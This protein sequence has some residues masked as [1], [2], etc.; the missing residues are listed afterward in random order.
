MLVCNHYLLQELDGIANHGWVVDNV[1]AGFELLHCSFLQQFIIHMKTLRMSILLEHVG[2]PQTTYHGYYI[3]V[4]LFVCLATDLE[5]QDFLR[6]KKIK[7][8]KPSSKLLDVLL[9]VLKRRPSEALPSIQPSSSLRSVPAHSRFIP[10]TFLLSS[11][12]FAATKLVRYLKRKKETNKRSSER[13][14][15][16]FL[17]N[18]AKKS[19]RNA[20]KKKFLHER[21]PNLSVANKMKK[22][23]KGLYHFAQLHPFQEE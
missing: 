10:S 13:P 21:D 3:L 14:L 18:K 19:W 6:G 2:C 4:V 17:P 11:F 8:L 16:F 1:K 15:I 9:P 22:N 23:S 12:S 7:S 20:L 5:L